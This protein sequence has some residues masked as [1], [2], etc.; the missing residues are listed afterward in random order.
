MRLPVVAYFCEQSFA[1]SSCRLFRARAFLSELLF[2]SVELSTMGRCVPL[3]VEHMPTFL[4][5]G[6]CFLLQLQGAP[7]LGECFSR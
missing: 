4:L 2:R 7:S 5:H 6:V 1:G 3:C